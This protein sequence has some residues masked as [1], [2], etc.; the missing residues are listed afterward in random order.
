M[1]HLGRCHQQVKTGEKM[2]S[3]KQ[4]KKRGFFG[5]LFRLIGI[6][7]LIILIAA[8]GLSAFILVK[9]NRDPV[10]TR[11]IQEYLDS[12]PD[13]SFRHLSFNDDA[14][15]NQSYS[16]ED[17][18]YFLGRNRPGGIADGDTC[19]RHRTEGL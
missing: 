17:I 10:E 13:L 8:A 18:G 19:Q 16:E 4:K 12:E 1:R 3:E 2:K 5:I 6:I 9:M 15:M 14:V 11:S 7:I